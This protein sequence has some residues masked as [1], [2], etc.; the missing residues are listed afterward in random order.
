[1]GQQ[2]A[3]NGLEYDPLFTLDTDL[4]VWLWRAQHLYAFGDSRFWGQKAAPGITNASQGAFDFSK[5][6]LDLNLG[7]AWNYYGMLEARA[8]AYSSNNLNRGTSTAQPSGFNDGV[9]LEQRWYVGGTYAELGQ[10]GFDVAQATFVSVG[11]Y[12][13]KDMVD[14]DGNLFK[15]GL[16]LRSYLTLPLIEDRWYLF[17]DAQAIATRSFL[18]E[19]LYVDSGTAVR[20]FPHTQQIEFRLGSENRYDPQIHE[21]ETGC[22]GAMRV[23]F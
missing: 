22:Y 17:V 19:T 8:F 3:P 12:P 10:T 6:E 5:R 1:L 15:P 20:P 21:L 4:N 11:Y 2:I 7:L 18:M 23:I 16:F 13:T 9:G 14:A